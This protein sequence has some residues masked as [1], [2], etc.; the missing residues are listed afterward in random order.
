M[1]PAAKRKTDCKTHSARGQWLSLRC[2][3][4]MGCVITTYYVTC[5]VCHKE[6][7][8]FFHIAQAGKDGV[9]KRCRSWGMHHR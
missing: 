9:C 6:K 4:P 3:F 1:M 5:R 7:G 8:P 2:G